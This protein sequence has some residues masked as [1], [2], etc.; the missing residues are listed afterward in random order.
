LKNSS[1]H[2]FITWGWKLDV[3]AQPDTVRHPIGTSATDLVT[4]E[5]AG[6]PTAEQIQTIVPDVKRQSLRVA[7]IGNRDA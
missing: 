1:R 5:L 3:E 4:Q 6:G 7:E 2:D